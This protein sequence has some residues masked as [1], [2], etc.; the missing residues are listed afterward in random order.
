MSMIKI[1]HLT[2]RLTT[3]PNPALFGSYEYTILNLVFK[4]YPDSDL[5]SV[6][7][8]KA[9]EYKKLVVIKDLEEYKKIIDTGWLEKA[10]DKPYKT[11]DV[12]DTSH[13][14]VEGYQWQNPILQYLPKFD[15][16]RYSEYFTWTPTV[17]GILQDLRLLQQGVNLSRTTDDCYLYSLISALD[18]FWD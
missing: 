5:Y 2:H 6:F 7:R 14:R 1:L 13:L 8:D 9:E 17:Q 12:P 10:L 3:K 4:V 18:Y 15:V 11:I 16:F